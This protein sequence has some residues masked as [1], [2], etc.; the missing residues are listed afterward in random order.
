MTKTWD[1]LVYA[2]FTPGALDSKI[3]TEIK[4]CF[5][6]ILKFEWMQAGAVKRQRLMYFEKFRG[7]LPHIE[8][9][10]GSFNIEITNRAGLLIS[11]V[12]MLQRLK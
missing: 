10:L 9:R 6:G 2:I 12:A 3:E 8:E 5:D 7:L 11:R 1:G 4:S